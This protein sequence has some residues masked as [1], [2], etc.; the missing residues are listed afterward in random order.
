[1]WIIFGVSA[2]IAA[3]FNV[4]WTIK[5]RDSKWFRFISISLTAF[6][7]CA[8]YSLVNTWVKVG[9]MSALMDVVPG[10]TG[11]LWIW[12]TASIVINSISLFRYK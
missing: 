3:V 11:A 5:G 9:D 8:E 2:I 7:V 4:I 1:M 6:T 12:V 10:M